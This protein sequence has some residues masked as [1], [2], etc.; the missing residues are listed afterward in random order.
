MTGNSGVGKSTVCELLKDRGELA[1]DADWEGYNH[2]VDRVS[3]QAVVDPP[4]PV[5]AGWL[6]RFGWKIRRT[7]V[8]TLAAG[9]HDR[10]AFMFGAVEN[11]HEVWDL[12][13]LVIC[14]VIDNE[15]LRH[16]LLTRTTNTFGQHPEELAAALK[17]NDRAE[18]TYRRFGATIIDGTR[19]LAEVADA[20]LAAA[21]RLS[22][23]DASVPRRSSTGD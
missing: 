23:A 17:D 12:F 21:G 16:R 10:T 11:E 1:V 6:D 13:D 7:E 20:I 19:P 8:E 18:A 22:I 14:L 3:G 15:T 5:P 4:Y 9:M 2:W